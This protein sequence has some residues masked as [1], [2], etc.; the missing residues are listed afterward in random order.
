MAEY[1]RLPA[2]CVVCGDEFEAITRP[3][4]DVFFGDIRAVTWHGD[5][6]VPVWAK[7]GAMAVSC[8]PL[9]HTREQVD[10]AM[11]LHGGAEAFWL[12]RVTESVGAD[13]D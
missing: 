13:G 10:Q 9:V 8:G 4:S 1:I 6:D 2:R 3:E 5:D 7:D 11:R 12:Y